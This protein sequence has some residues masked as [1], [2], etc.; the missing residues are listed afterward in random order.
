MFKIEQSI[1]HYRQRGHSDVIKLIDEWFI[2]RL[3][4]EH[5]P[6]SKEELRSHIQNIFVESVQDQQR[7]ASVGFSS[8]NEHER[9]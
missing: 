5:G 3:A 8:V 6:E 1:E 4:R 2:E 9:F 7:I